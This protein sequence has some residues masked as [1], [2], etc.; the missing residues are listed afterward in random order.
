MSSNSSSMNSCS[1]VLPKLNGATNAKQQRL[2]VVR[3]F[4]D[5][6]GYSSTNSSA[7]FW[8]NP[9]S[10]NC[11]LLD[12]RDF[13]VQQ[14]ILENNTKDEPPQILA[15]VYL[16]RYSSYMVLD[17]AFSDA[18]TFDFSASTRDQPMTLDIRLTD[19]EG[20]SSSSA[21]GSEA[22]NVPKHCNMSPAGLYAFTMINGLE[23]T[24]MLI[25][26][27]SSS[28]PASIAPSFNLIYG[29]YAFFIGGLLQLL[30]GMW[31][32]TRVRSR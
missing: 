24:A 13:L 19:L 8:E 16:D 2:V 29:P 28:S 15:E 14:N 11:T 7:R 32:V 21:G 20:L 9:P 4:L 1:L 5:R 3:Y 10:P 30:V 17:A 23:A 25:G 26:L 22:S 27:I 31:E 6:P 18:V 12:I